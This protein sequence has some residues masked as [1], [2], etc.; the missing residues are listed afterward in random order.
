[1]RLSAEMYK[2]IVA[3]LKSDSHQHRDKRREPR[4]GMAGEVEF[5]TVDET[6]KR[7]AGAVKIRDISRSGVGLLFN[8]P[9]LA[10]QRFVIQLASAKGEPVWLVCT[11]AY[12]RR[13]EEGWFSI[14]ARI[15]QLLRAEQIQQIE[16]KSSA[17]QPAPTEAMRGISLADRADVARISRAIL[18]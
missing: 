13:V 2:Q 9:V 3:G 8:K 17:P 18:G 10:Q 11:T 1:M 16:S 14:G 6:G 7:V 15:I 4:V 12:C 5:V